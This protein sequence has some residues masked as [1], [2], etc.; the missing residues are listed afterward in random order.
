MS[1]LWCRAPDTTNDTRPATERVTLLEAEKILNP[2]SYDPDRRTLTLPQGTENVR[3]SHECCLF[4]HRSVGL[5]LAK[6]RGNLIHV[7]Y[8]LRSAIF[9]SSPVLPRVRTCLY[10]NGAGV[11]SPSPGT[12]GGLPSRTKSCREKHRGQR[13]KPRSAATTSNYCTSADA[14]QPRQEK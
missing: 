2:T 5:T 7:R 4:L 10:S 3:R 6:A 8:P 14:I 13:V 11:S 12:V 1:S 9:S